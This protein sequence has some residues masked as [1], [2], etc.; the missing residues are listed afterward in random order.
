MVREYAGLVGIR[1]RRAPCGAMGLW[2]DSAV[3]GL[4]GRARSVHM[5]RAVRSAFIKGGPHGVTWPACRAVIA[6]QG[7]DRVEA[8]AGTSPATRAVMENVD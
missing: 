2:H 5:G 8:S 1:L 7:L 6:I 4:Q 3:E